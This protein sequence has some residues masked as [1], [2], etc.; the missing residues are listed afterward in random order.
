MRADA[1][2]SSY[3]PHTPHVVGLTD[4]ASSRECSHSVRERTSP[5]G[6]SPTCSRFRP[7]CPTSLRSLRSTGIT[8]LLRYY[9][10]SDSC[11]CGSSARG[12]R[13]NT[14]LGHEQVSL[15]HAHRRHDHSVSNHPPCP[16]TAF[17]RYPSAA[18]VSRVTHEWRFRSFLA[19]SSLTKGRIEFVILRTSHSPPVAPHLASRRRSD[20]WLRAGERM[21]GEDFHLPVGVRV[22]A[23]QVGRR[24]AAFPI[25]NWRLKRGRTAEPL[26][27][28]EATRTCRRV[29]PNL[30]RA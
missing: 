3:M 21:P 8:P 12:P 27:R 20:R 18:A 6:H 10:R 5:D 17:T 22:E 29:A 24:S 1:R 2:S 11:S 23:H 4:T 28:G 16:A 19:G 9:G 15:R 26:Q 7:L 13:M 14:A 30:Q 25:S